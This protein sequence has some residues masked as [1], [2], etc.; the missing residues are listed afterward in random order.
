MIDIKG[1]N[2]L[3][4][5]A[6]STG[7][8]VA[9][10]LLER[11]ANVILNDKK[12]ISVNLEH[13]NLTLV[14]NAHP[15]EVFKNADLIILSPG[16]NRKNLPI[17]EGKKVIGDIELFYHFN[18]SKIIA[19]TGTNGK[20]TTTTLV[21]MI[22]NRKYKTFVGGNIGTPCMNF[23]KRGESFEYSV[24]ELSSFQLET[25]EDFTADVAAILNITPDHLDRYDNFNEYV[26]AKMRLFENQKRGQIFIANKNIEKFIQ[27]RGVIY[28]DSQKFLKKGN[29]LVEFENKSVKLR[30]E[31]ILLK[32]KHFYEDIYVAA[33]IGLICNIEGDVIEEIIYNFKGLEHR[34]E[35]VVERDGVKYY[36]DSKSTTVTSTCSAIESFDE[37]VILILGG[38]QKGESFKKIANY[39][40]V[41]KVICFGEAKNKISNELKTIS[42]I[43]VNTLEDA[44]NEAKKLSEKSNVIL[45]SPACASFDMFENYK[46]RGKRFKEI[47]ND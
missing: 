29:I 45:F 26:S 35:F 8:S 34:L 13:S 7:V 3:V 30:V 9:E 15:E 5:G 6:G 22:L 21:G 41:K 20:T 11:N 18:E 36:N 46:E 19:I 44:V 14:E 24:L 17:P 47:V 40:N 28:F 31:K 16:I 37:Q 25:I 32:G 33:L 2:I 38:V 1:K 42:P 4:V 12:S 27:N 10:F 23:F 43:L 39:N